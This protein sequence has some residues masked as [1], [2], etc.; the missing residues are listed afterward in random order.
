MSGKK[1]S[2]NTQGAKSA[3]KGTNVS[4]S[5]TDEPDEEAMVFEDPYGDEYDEE[6]IEA[7]R[8]AQEADEGM[9]N[10]EGGDVGKL[11]EGTDTDVKRVFRPGV[12]ELPEGE[13][14][15]YDP[16]AYVMYHSL[17]AEWPCLSFDIFR[18]DKGSNRQRFPHSLFLMSGSQADKRDANKLTLLKLSDLGKTSKLDLDDDDDDDDDSDTDDD[19]DYEPVLENVD[20]PHVG[21]VNRLR[22]MPVSP[23]G[24]IQPGLV[25][26]M[27]DTG[28]AHIYDLRAVLAAMMAG[29]PYPRNS[30]PTKPAH[31]M[32]AH[33]T[34]GY[35]LDWSRTVLGRLASGD[36]HSTL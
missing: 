4:K 33:S 13:E 21:G 20:I 31:T 6:D 17:T 22:C 8:A 26:T 27:A 34:E 29:Q 23:G 14:L 30:V 16:R 7:L 5:G 24:A 32:T 28:Q 1:R 10:G 36:Q 2:A 19:I 15:T 18:D 3:Q 9:G 12:D 25:A 35:A 11:P